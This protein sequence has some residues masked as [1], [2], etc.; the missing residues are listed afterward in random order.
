MQKNFKM[1]FHAIA[2]V[3]LAVHSENE[4]KIYF[5]RKYLNEKKYTSKIIMIR[6][7]L[8]IN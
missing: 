1:I 8:Q 2:N 6:S 3:A 4:I 7:L 5:K